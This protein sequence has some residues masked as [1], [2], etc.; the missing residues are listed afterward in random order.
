MAPAA[1]EGERELEHRCRLGGRGVVERLERQRKERIKWERSGSGRGCSF[2]A[3]TH[4][5][6]PKMVSSYHGVYSFVF[7]QS[8]S[9]SCS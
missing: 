6:P 3:V 9:R 8:N 5:L 1:G 4:V 2:N 7:A